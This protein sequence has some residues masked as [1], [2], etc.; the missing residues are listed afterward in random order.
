MREAMSQRYDRKRWYVQPSE[1]LYEEAR[2]QNETTSTVKSAPVK[3]LTLLVGSSLPPLSVKSDKVF[4]GFIQ[5]LVLLYF[6]LS[7]TPSADLMLFLFIFLRVLSVLQF[8]YRMPLDP[9]VHLD[10]VVHYKIYK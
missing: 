5:Q 2:Q 1:A 3:P 9:N 8:L 10:T 6:Y 7:F 4:I